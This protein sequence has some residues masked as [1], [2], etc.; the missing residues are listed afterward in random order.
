MYPRE[1]EVGSRL[2]N[3]FG[4]SGTLLSP[5]WEGLFAWVLWDDA[6]DRGHPPETTLVTEIV[7]YRPRPHPRRTNVNA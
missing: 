3:R 2:R 7:E 5:V 4:H 6:R 1:W